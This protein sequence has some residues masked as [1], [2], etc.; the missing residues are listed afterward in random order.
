MNS[1]I[2][3]GR[4]FLPAYLLGPNSPCEL[5]KGH[6]LN[7]EDALLTCLDHILSLPLTG[8]LL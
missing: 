2:I 7:K 6:A 8:S 4:F 5:W 1:S 3:L